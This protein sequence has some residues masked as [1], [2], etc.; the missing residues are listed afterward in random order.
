MNFPSKYRPCSRHPP[1]P[2][3]LL[4]A[5]VS[6]LSP[7]VSLNA[8]SAGPSACL[9]CV[10]N[11]EACPLG[12]PPSGDSL[13]GQKEHPSVRSRGQGRGQLPVGL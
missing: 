6:V 5:N 11:C 10:D 8:Q 4:S 1:E 7:F 12:L 3:L 9:N 13:M 2:E